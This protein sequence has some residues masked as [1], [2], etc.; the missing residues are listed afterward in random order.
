M[1]AA[2]LSPIACALVLVAGS[3]GA[4]DKQG[5]AHGG[6]S[7]GDE[8]EH[9]FKVSGQ[10]TLGASIDNPTYA[11]RPDN[12]GLALYRY[13][14]HADVDLLGR[15]LSIPLDLNLFT[16][17]TEPGKRRFTPSEFDVIGG[18]TTTRSLG[19]PG[20]IEL[21]ARVEHDRPADRAG[22][23][24]TYV[25]ARGRYLYSLRSFFPG[26]DRALG[27]G[28]V[29][30]WATLGAFVVN[31]TY[32]ARPDNTGKALFRYAL[33]AETSFVDETFAI[34]LDGTMFTDRHASK[35]GP[36]E[37]DFTPEAIVHLEQFDVHLAFERDMPI[38]HHGLVQ[39]FVYALWCYSFAPDLTG[40]PHPKVPSP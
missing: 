40:R 33:H 2:P 18:L 1:R 4:L 15:A 20:S 12:T 35:I 39:S 3:A 6:Q 32:A 30:G 38:D 21:G 5:S 19:K 27:G 9:G 25:D 13:A 23:T 17:R 31:P 34:G 26:L 16:D 37:L 10:V 36:S 11:A 14:L 24:Q 7:A 29:A 28:D 8:E 22:F